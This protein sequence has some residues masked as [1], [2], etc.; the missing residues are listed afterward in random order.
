ME[1]RTKL[2]AS[3]LAIFIIFATGAKAANHDYTF[4][5]DFTPDSHISGSIEIRLQNNSIEPALIYLEDSGGRRLPVEYSFDNKSIVLSS[6]S[7]ISDVREISFIFRSRENNDDIL[8][9]KI[10]SRRW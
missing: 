9:A 5:A 8:R 1:F 4:Q 10:F 7:G 2:A 3:L 6:N